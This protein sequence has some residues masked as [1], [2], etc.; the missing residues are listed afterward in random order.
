[1][2]DTTI[3]ALNGADLRTQDV[4]SLRE[5]LRDLLNT[6]FKLRMQHAQQGLANT[7]EIRI[8]RRNIACVRTILGE[9]A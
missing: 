1:M 8:V 5:T 3:K 7:G 2:T 6:Q 4:N 9:K